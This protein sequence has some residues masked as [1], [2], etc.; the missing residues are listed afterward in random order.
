MQARDATLRRYLVTTLL[1]CYV[2]GS[3]ARAVNDVGREDLG[4]GA[5]AAKEPSASRQ[6]DVAVA[7]REPVSGSTRG[8][9]MLQRRQVRAPLSSAPPISWAEEEPA[10]SPADGVPVADSRR[11]RRSTIGTPRYPLGCADGPLW[12]HEAEVSLGQW[13]SAKPFSF[14]Q[15]ESAIAEVAPLANSSNEGSNASSATAQLTSVALD[16]N[17][18]PPA[19]FLRGTPIAVANA[20]SAQH[21]RDHGAGRS[22]RRL[23]VMGV[24]VLTVLSLTFILRC[25]L[26]GTAPPSPDAVRTEVEKIRVTRGV[27]LQSMFAL[28]STSGANADK[29]LCPGL[30]MRIQGRVVAGPGSSLTSPFSGRPSV[31]YSASVTR[32]GSLD[33]VHQPPLAFHSAGADFAVQLSDAPDIIVQVHGQDV[34]L[35]DMGDGQ[36]QSEQVFQEAPDA[37]RGFVLAHH[38]VNGGSELSAKFGSCLDLG[39]DGAELEFRECALTVGAEVTCVGE[40]ARDRSGGLGLFPWQ[41]SSGPMDATGNA[42][43]DKFGRRRCLIGQVRISDAAEL[44]GYSTSTQGQRASDGSPWLRWTAIWSQLSMKSMLAGR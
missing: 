9:I 22:K 21:V 26:F 37:W 10:S 8:M 35:F 5:V 43:A 15:E 13:K 42:A 25:C 4:L 20:T 41:P 1:W 39:S 14:F 34:S 2:F 23:A 27:D 24:V 16:L 36:H 29:P 19:G 31:L 30:L 28:K 17:A 32:K 33:G 18:V 7:S 3:E 12:R 44:I 40:V 11:R 38:M 6:V